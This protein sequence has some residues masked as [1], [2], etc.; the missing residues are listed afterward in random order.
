MNKKLLGWEQEAGRVF[1]WARGRG[2]GTL[3]L[4]CMGGETALH[5]RAQGFGTV[6]PETPLP[7]LH[8]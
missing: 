4:D 5:H 6:V 8:F 1:C 2:G 3:P 7:L